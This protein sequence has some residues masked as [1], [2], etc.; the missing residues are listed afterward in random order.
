MTTVTAYDESVDAFLHNAVP[1]LDAVA[2]RYAREEDVAAALSIIDG[3]PEDKA[4]VLDLWRT[5]CT[6]LIKRGEIAPTADC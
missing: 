4:F 6:G 1:L 2:R 5:V 3:A